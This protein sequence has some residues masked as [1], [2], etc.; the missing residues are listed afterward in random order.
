MTDDGALQGAH[1]Q[2]AVIMG[3]QVDDQPVNSAAHV[4]HGRPP[5][6]GI[7]RPQGGINQDQPMLPVD[8]SQGDARVCRFHEYMRCN[9]L[10]QFQSF[11]LEELR[12]LSPAG[13][14]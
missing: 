14:T 1:T 13:K 4:Q 7:F 10:H 8:G 9:F 2:G 12:C 6:P 3:I 11:H 5:Q